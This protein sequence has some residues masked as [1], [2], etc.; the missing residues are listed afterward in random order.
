MNLQRC[1]KTRMEVIR[2]DLS[3]RDFRDTRSYSI[4]KMAQIL[5]TSPAQYEEW[6]QEQIFLDILSAFL[7]TSEEERRELLKRMTETSR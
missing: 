4:E 6:E 1:S 3:L 7:Y 2:L 5:H